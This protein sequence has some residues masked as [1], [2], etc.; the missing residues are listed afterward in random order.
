LARTKE[1]SP[2]G[3]AVAPSTRIKI[4]I[5]RAVLKLIRIGQSCIVH[6]VRALAS[7]SGSARKLLL[8]THH[9]VGDALETATAEYWRDDFPRHAFQVGT[10]ALNRGDLL[11][12]HRAFA[13]A[14]HLRADEDSSFYEL[15][16]RTLIELKDAAEEKAR[17]IKS[18]NDG[19]A[20]YV[21][22]A[23]VWGDEYIDNFMTYTMRSLL[24]PGNLPAL[25]DGTAH[26]SIITTPPGVERIKSKPSFA[27]LQQHAQVHFFA[28]PE[29]LTKPFHY[30]RPNYHFYRLYGALDHTS[31][32]FAR[33]LRAPIFFIVVDGI[34]SS[35]TL[36][37]LRRYLDEG[38][39]I[40]ANASIVSNRETL[41][42]ALDAMYGDSEVISISARELANLG[43]AHVHHYTAQRL[44]I[45]GN[46]DF[47][48]YPREL[49]FPTAEGLVVH[50]IYQHPLVISANAICKDV[51][52]DYFIVDAKLMARIFTDARDFKRLKVITDSDEAYMA[53]FAPRSRIFDA[54]G[55]AL[56]VDDFV[57][58]HLESA[59]IHHYI[60]QHRQLI[61][62][63][64]PLRTHLDPARM[65]GE[66]LTALIARQQKERQV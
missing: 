11:G 43:L 10:E 22:A 54:T 3:G 29:E 49:Y 38:Y 40:C 45:E 15:L 21:F 24:A 2:I 32:H 6:A 9:R 42:P 47:D 37:T 66:F 61:R 20:H 56:N 4:A 1:T 12:A 57:A 14:R 26:M 55:R 59:P 30:S 39:D 58:V 7:R 50:A 13:F 62:C 46:R 34:L 27:G 65:S 52:F 25:A 33:A 63:D 19:R 60:W 8:E 41:L 53:N 5:K 31:I 36:R 28:F 44:V 48:K 35:N 51:K 16:T 17:E 18:T 23:V 64:T